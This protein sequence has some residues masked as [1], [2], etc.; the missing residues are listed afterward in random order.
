MRRFNLILRKQFIAAFCG[1]LLLGLCSCSAPSYQLQVHMSPQLKQQFKIYPSLE[2][3][4]VGINKNEFDRIISYDVD[5][6]FTPGNTLRKSLNPYTLKFSEDSPKTQIMSRDNNLWTL[7]GRR[8]A[9]KVMLIVNLPIIIAKGNPD[10]RKIIIPLENSIW[11]SDKRY[12]EVSPAEIIQLTQPAKETEDVAD[13]SS[14]SG[15]GTTDNKKKTD[16]NKE[17]KKK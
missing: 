5:N 14:A 9:D 1:T 8:S 15:A 4:V 11:H 16:N 6:Y 2:V 7:W 13:S 12:F 3:D 10:S 17:E